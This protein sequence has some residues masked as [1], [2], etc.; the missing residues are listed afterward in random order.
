MRA[1]TQTGYGN[2]AQSLESCHQ[3]R[4]EARRQLQIT[5]PTGAGG[6]D[7][8]EYWAIPWDRDWVTR[9]IER[10]WD[11]SAA[12]A[13]ALSADIERDVLNGP[14]TVD[15]HALIDLIDERV[16]NFGL[17]PWCLLATMPSKQ[18]GVD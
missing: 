12:A 8:Q 5:R 14:Q 18:K 4:T 9:Q 16:D 2:A 6:P 11:I 13:A 3:H 17:A 7:D 1:L 10:R 15:R